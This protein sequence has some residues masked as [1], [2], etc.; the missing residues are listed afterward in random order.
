MSYV[1]SQNINV[2]PSTKRGQYQRD[3]RLMTE[4]SLVGLINELIDL[5]SFVITPIPS[6]TLQQS[7]LF[8]FNIAGY[9]FKIDRLDS[10]PDFN[11]LATGES[12]VASITLKTDNKFTELMGQD[13][14]GV[15]KAITFEQ[16]NTSLAPI[17]ST[18]SIDESPTVRK[19]T[20]SLR[21][22]D[23]VSD[24]KITIDVDAKIKFQKDSLQGIDG[25]EL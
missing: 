5:K 12:I 23:K 7:D 6:D 20:Y 8:E 10:I 16:K 17:R 21:I 13:D 1:G 19:T 9:Y 11:S 24:D 22:L 15:Y 14:S 4:S 3:A 2:F 18:T 25:G